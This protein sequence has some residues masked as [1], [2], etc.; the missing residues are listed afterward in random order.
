MIAYLSGKI[1]QKTLN[2]LVI[3]VNGVGYEVFIS[4]VTLEKTP[5]LGENIHL[6][7]YTHVTEGSISLFGFFNPSEKI[8]FKKLLGVSGIGPKTALQILSGISTENLVRA[9]VEENVP[10]LTSINGIGRKTAER[11]VVELKDKLKELFDELSLRE[12][13]DG[14]KPPVLVYDE[15]LSALVN[16]G[17][18]KQEAEKVLGQIKLPKEAGLQEWLKHSLKA[19]R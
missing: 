16:L 10:K 11:L 2:T 17:Y 19:M 1:L 9:V 3:N 13:S 12:F 7:I 15:A 4:K 8:V 14:V 6:P 5:A 18:N